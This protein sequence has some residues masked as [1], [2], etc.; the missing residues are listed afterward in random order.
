MPGFSMEFDVCPI[1][2]KPLEIQSVPMEFHAFRDWV[3]VLGGKS[4][5][6][7][8][9]AFVEARIGRLAINRVQMEK[10]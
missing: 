8:V 10:I 3:P 2:G 5:Q 7:W 6:V 9:A 4:R 1:G